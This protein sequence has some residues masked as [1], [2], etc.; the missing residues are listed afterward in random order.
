MKI[1]VIIPTYNSE[2]TIGDCLRS[3]NTQTFPPYEIIVVDGGSMDSTIEKV[4][5]F[6]EVKLIINEAPDTPGSA[7]NRGAEITGGNIIFFCDSDCIVDQ[8]AL[9]YYLKAYKSREDISGVMGLI[10]NADPGKIV[11]DFVQNLII[12]NSWSGNL[13]NDGTIKSYFC[14]ANFTIKRSDFLLEKFRDDLVSCEDVELFLRLNKNRLKIFYEPR[15]VVYH[16]HPTTVEQLFRQ[17]KW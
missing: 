8:R 17:Y 2:K 13:K 10:R 1:S 4:K 14:S 11:S 7:R 5:E 6:K 3:L 15:A 9:E 16:Y 12:T